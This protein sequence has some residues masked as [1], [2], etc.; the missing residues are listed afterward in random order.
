MLVWSSGFPGKEIFRENVVDICVQG[1]DCF[2]RRWSVVVG[3]AVAAVLE[4]ALLILVLRSHDIEDVDLL[5]SREPE[6]SG[7]CLGFV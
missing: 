4:G 1:L 2:V 3:A 7:R 6:A 5:D